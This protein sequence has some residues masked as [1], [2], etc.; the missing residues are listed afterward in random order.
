[1]TLLIVQIL[2]SASLVLAVYMCVLTLERCR[3]EKR[4]MFV[5]FIVT[6]FLYTFGYFVEISCGN[7]Y[8]A[9]IGIKIMYT[10]GSFM[11]PLFFFFVADYCEIR[12]P[13]KYYR[14]PLLIIP[15]LHYLFVLT[16]DMH[17]LIY[18]N[19]SYNTQQFIQS[20][21]I[22]PGPLYLIGQIYPLFVIVLSCIIL[23]RS[24]I[25]QSKW[26]RSGLI[27]LLIGSLAPL[28]GNLT[29]VAMSYIIE[30][31]VAGI[32]FTPFMLVICNFI[33]YYNIIR[34]DMFDIA[35]KAHAITMDLIRDAFVVLDRGMAY[36]GS[37]KKAYELFPALAELH[38]GASTTGH[39]DWPKELLDVT[40]TDEHELNLVK[41]EIEFT[42]PHK[43]GNIYSAWENRVA[44]ESGATL[45]WV[46][47]IQDITETVSL[48][49]NIQSQRDEI[50]TMRDNLKE[51]IF[52][53]DKEFQIQDSY[54][55]AM[56][57]ILSG[58]NLKG[59]RFTDLLSKSFYPKDLAII[60]DYFNMIINKTIETEML[61]DLNPL[62]E[63]S[64]TSTETG[65]HKT[66]RCLFAP[67]DQGDGRIFVLG[68]IQDISAETML[69]KQLAEEEA[70]REEEMHS[71]FEVMQVD[72][73]VFANF[74]EDTDY[75]FNRVK[76]MKKKKKIPNMQKVINVYQSVHS[77]KS[78]ALIV[79]LSS[80]GEK[81]H[82][83]ETDLKVLLKKEK[84]PAPDDILQICVEIEKYSEDE[85]KLNDVVKKLKDFSAADTAL[86]DEDVFIKSLERVCQKVAGDEGKKVNL[87]VESFDTE[88]LNRGPRRVMK[89]ILIQLARNAVHHGIKTPEERLAQG[90]EETGKVSLSVTIENN[91]VRMVLSDDGNG[92]NFDGIAKKAKA[93]GLLP[94]GEASR[95]LLTSLIF[96]PGFSTSETED[97]HAGRGIGLNLVKS[98]LHEVKGNMDIQTKEGRGLTFIIQIPFQ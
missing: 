82:K 85:E 42:L 2:I 72:Q 35:P 31:S 12:I 71:L 9:I 66:L 24:I 59:K 75:E 68:T 26:R 23:I 20:M 91:N 52:L 5:Y 39:N 16:F 88:A 37:N 34:N 51:G 70:R 96:S 53:M 78:N 33:L 76:E 38:K 10:G 15:G 25:T 50:A 40:S 65:E 90:K 6:I 22:E 77:I 69:K 36:M 80:Y 54:S 89:D 49:R 1:M 43:P 95:Q 58:R 63:F 55:R 27:L 7:L 46:I 73:K 62:T 94:S 79:G 56:E 87:T 45:G 28:L 92:L 41:K 30:T 11:S 98:R 13:K 60:T 19:Y 86:N 44:S 48:I 83:F 67:V 17:S 18:R 21:N 84:D 3:S 29:Y 8:G 57:E 81:L 64:Y 74:I 14:I 61:E 93:Q 32:N 47:L 4:Y 97:I